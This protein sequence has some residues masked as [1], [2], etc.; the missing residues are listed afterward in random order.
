MFAKTKNFNIKFLI[1]SII[2]S[3]VVIAFLIYPNINII[4]GSFF[5]NGQFTFD[6]FRKIFESE[7]AMDSIKNSFLLAVTLPI[8]INIV[9]I[10][11]VLVSEYFD[12]KGSSILKIGFLS[13]LVFGGLI[14]NNGF[15]FLYGE[16]GVFTNILASI[17]PNF[18]RE[19]FS[20]YMAV[21]IVMTFGCTT[22]HM[23]FLSSAL[24]NID[25]QTIEAAKNLGASQWTILKKVVF[26]VIMPVITT[27]TILAFNTGLGA[28]SAPLIVGGGD[29]QTIT[30][31]MLDFANRPGSR[32]LATILSMLLGLAQIFLL[33]FLT[34][35]ERKGNYISASKVKTKIKK[36]KIKNPVI[37]T[38]VHIIAYILF[39]I[40]SL[41]VLAV[42][43]YSF[44]DTQAIATGR[45]TWDSFTLENYIGIFTDSSNY[46]PF[47]T[48]LVYS[49]LAA[50]IVVVGMLIIIRVVMKHVNFFTKSLEYILF[51]PWLLPGVM[52]AL[53]L[54]TTYST[55]RLIMF[56]QVLTGTLVMVLFAYIIVMIPFTYRVLKSAYFSFDNNLEDAARSLGA[57]GS[58]TFRRVILPIL[59]PTAL[60]VFAMNLIGKLSEYDLSAFLYHPLYPTLG[61]II[62]SNTDPS[63]EP[64]A[65]AINLVYS[66][67]IMAISTLV[68]YLIKRRS[69]NNEM[70]M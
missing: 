54:L 65:K 14:Q 46:G 56:N 21:M 10:F 34:R 31:L 63:A 36:Q 55:S 32:D 15:V 70:F 16:T 53:A 68:I 47:V 58:Y 1:F 52:I 44:T 26:P 59:A 29:F 67:I 19:W 8:T 27:L 11:I 37:N 64:E 48:S 2:V 3:W 30:P 57:S 39:L 25:Y 12:I 66:V 51:I 38:I 28:F 6:G 61:I 33:Y 24:K 7:R 41:P 23:L 13:T 62:R 49:I 42:I 17:F 5:E 40:Y 22:L 45:I 35:S 69:K 50:L 9:G 20:G 4:I 60:A 18:D 43:V